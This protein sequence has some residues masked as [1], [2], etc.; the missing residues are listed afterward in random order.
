MSTEVVPKCAMFYSVN[1]PYNSLS[2]LDLATRL[3]KES[4]REIQF[5]Y[6]SVT[7]FCTLSPMPNFITWLKSLINVSGILL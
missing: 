2:G 3:I 4:V 1:S 7:C 6:P 5:E